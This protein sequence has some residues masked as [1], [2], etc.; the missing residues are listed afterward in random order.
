M[1]KAIKTEKVWSEY[2]AAI[3]AFLQRKIS[4]P[5][6]VDDLLQEILIKVHKNLSSLESVTKTKAWLFQIANNTIIDFYRKRDRGIALSA[7]DLWYSEENDQAQQKLAQC[8]TP[9]IKALPKESADLLTEIELHGRS[10]KE[11][12]DKFGINYSTLKSRVQK[13]RKQLRSL[14][15]GCC[16]LSIDKN[17]AIIDFDPKY[18]CKKC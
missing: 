2:R 12:A 3:K 17:G 5:D 11:V 18:K 1:E 7:D 6:E 15:E 16:D 9:F 4:D 8:V 13:G 14:F 10:Q